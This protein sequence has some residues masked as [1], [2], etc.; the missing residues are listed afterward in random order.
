MMLLCLLCLA[1][2]A[3][4]MPDSEPL[5]LGKYPAVVQLQAMNATWQRVR[6]ITG[7]TWST[8]LVKSAHGPA[9]TATADTYFTRGQ[10]TV[11][12]GATYLVLYRVAGG[13]EVTA[14]AGAALSLIRVRDIVAVQFL[15]PFDLERTLALDREPAPRRPAEDAEPPRRGNQGLET[16]LKVNLQMVRNAIEQFQADTGAYP[17]ALTDLVL[18]LEQ[19]PAAGVDRDG[20]AVAIPAG[21]YAGPY[22]APVGGISGAAGIPVNPLVNPQAA[23]PDPKNVATHWKYANGTLTVPDAMAETVGADGAKYGEY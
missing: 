13:P 19:A 21:K 20:K 17:A 11:L 22:L 4:G 7:T 1:A 16:T 9:D 18:P 8:M 23:D 5:G 12:H 10:T 2:M 6:V 15:G 3:Q 14:D